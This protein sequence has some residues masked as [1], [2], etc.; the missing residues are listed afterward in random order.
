MTSPLTATYDAVDNRTKLQDSLNG[1]T[2]FVY[3]ALNRLTSEQFGGSGQTALRMDLTYTAQDE[4][5]TQT[6]YKAGTQTVGTSS[7]TYDA[8]GQLTN[9]QHKDGSSVLVRRFSRGRLLRQRGALSGRIRA[10]V[11]SRRCE[12]GVEW[13][14]IVMCKGAN[15]GWA[16]SPRAVGESDQVARGGAMPPAGW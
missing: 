3:D 5:A 10:V 16:P 11:A 14:T 7:F 9:L 4:I 2:T 6:R 15:M 12:P 1:V 13:Y 8:L